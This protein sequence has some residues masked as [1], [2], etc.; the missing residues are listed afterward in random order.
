MTDE[1]KLNREIEAGARASREYEAVKP[2]ID[3]I[4]ENLHRMWENT[5]AADSQLRESIWYQLKALSEIDRS[6]QNDIN[7]GKLASKEAEN[8]RN[9]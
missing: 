9:H 8:V 1:N 5:K 3:L 6:F 4:A 2:R 7:T